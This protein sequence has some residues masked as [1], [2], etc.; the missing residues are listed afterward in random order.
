MATI[1][2]ELVEN[3]PLLNS[4][5]FKK[6]FL[7]KPCLNNILNCASATLL[8]ANLSHFPKNFD[9]FS[10]NFGTQNCLK[11]TFLHQIKPIIKSLLQYDSQSSYLGQFKLFLVALIPGW[12]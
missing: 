10:I 2:S 7:M 12:N 11:N 8:K 1:L 4:E 9:Y 3:Y 5:K 6:A